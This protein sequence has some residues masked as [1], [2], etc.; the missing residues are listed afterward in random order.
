M[1]L[2]LLSDVHGTTKRPIARTDEDYSATFL[3]KFRQVLKIA[4]DANAPILIA[5]DFGDQAREWEYLNLMVALLRHRNVDIATVFGQHDIYQRNR[6]SINVVSTLLNMGYVSLLH[7]RPLLLGG[8]YSNSASVRVYGA[9]WGEQV[10]VVEENGKEMYNILVIHDRITEKP[11]NFPHV[12]CTPA[13][14]F[15]KN[16]PDYDVI[17]CGDIHKYFYLRAGE[18]GAYERSIINTGPLMRNT[19]EANMFNHQPIVALLDTVT[20]KIHTI[21]LDVRPAEQVLTREH[22]DRDKEITQM[23]TEFTESMQQVDSA[24]IDIHV[25]L[26]EYMKTVK[27]LNREVVKI[28]ERLLNGLRATDS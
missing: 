17:L 4:K 8:M 19:A 5:G 21:P 14:E 1:K 18:G 23:L 2:V 13:L 3:H 11:E 6:K 12:P 9:S 16:H 28:V 24:T 7:E 15:L 25:A 26:S 10:P 20:N 27:N 22:L